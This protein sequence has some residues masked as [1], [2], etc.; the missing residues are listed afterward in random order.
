[1]V[2]LLS[3]PPKPAVSIRPATFTEPKSERLSDRLAK[4]AQ[5]PL[6]SNS[7][8]RISFTH[9]SPDF[10][11]PLLFR[12]PIMMF[13]TFAIEGFPT[14]VILFPG[15]AGS[16]AE[17]GSVFTITPLR[18]LLRCS[19]MLVSASNGKSNIL[20]GFHTVN[21]SSSLLPVYT[22]SGVSRSGIS[23]S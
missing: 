2:T 21:L 16:G 10:V 9:I 13:S 7:D 8:M 11:C 17:K 14:M 12:T 5:P 3:M 1:M 19:L 15:L 4:P 6:S 23:Y 22:P 18:S 20:S